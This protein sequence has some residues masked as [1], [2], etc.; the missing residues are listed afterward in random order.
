MD[1]LI[2]IQEILAGE[3]DKYALLVKKYTDPVFRLVMGFVH[4]QQD[5][6][7]ITQEVFIRAYHALGRFEQR[8]S[9][10]TWLFRIAI[11]QSQTYI[12]RKKR[13]AA[14]EKTL[15]FFGAASPA[16][17]VTAMLDEKEEY[18]VVREALNQLPLRQQQAFIL[19]K[20]QEMSQREIAG[21]MHLTEGAVEQLLMRAKSRLRDYFEKKSPEP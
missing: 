2:I 8:A 1:E 17:S 4:Q 20:Y 5:A 6:E 12:K 21:L 10:S 18:R 15:A 19:S 7:D 13:R 14:W 11:N 16:G 9:F 3:Q